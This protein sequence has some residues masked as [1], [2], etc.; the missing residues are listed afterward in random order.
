MAPPEQSDFER[1]RQSRLRRRRQHRTTGEV[2]RFVQEL[3]INAA[4]IATVVIAR[5]PDGEQAVALTA[6]WLN[7]PWKRPTS[8]QTARSCS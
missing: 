8:R 7:G 3:P 4:G 1:D 5:E 6:N 2:W